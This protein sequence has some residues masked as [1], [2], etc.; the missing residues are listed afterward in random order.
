MY[1]SG[2]LLGLPAEKGMFYLVGE[3]PTHDI[4]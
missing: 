4:I 2:H 1:I 3:V